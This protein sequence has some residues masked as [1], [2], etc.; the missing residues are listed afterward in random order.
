MDCDEM[1][2]LINHYMDG[3]LSQ[4]RYRAVTKHI[5]ACPPCAQEHHYNLNYRHVV[6]SKCTEQ[7]PDALRMRI[8][9]ALDSLPVGEVPLD[10]SSGSDF[11]K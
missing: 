11:R 8:A 10:L 3:G 2:A 4:W 1:L 9:A 5:D 6:S 7:A